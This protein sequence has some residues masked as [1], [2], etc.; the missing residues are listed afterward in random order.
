MSLNSSEKQKLKSFGLEKL[1]KPKLTR[2]HPKKKAIVAIRDPK[3][4]K[5]KVLRFGDQSMGHNFSDEA[6]KSFKARHA[7]NIARGKT[8]P[9][10]WADKFLWSKG[11]LSKQPPKG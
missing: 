4:D 2:N 7:K 10:F 5:V 6:R 1:N 11:G 9:A 8:S 3:T